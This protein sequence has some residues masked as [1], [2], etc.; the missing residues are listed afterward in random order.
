MPP[1]GSR[2]EIYM[3]IG[4]IFKIRSAWNK[5]T[6]THPKF[7]QFISAVQRK[8]IK[9]N[10]IIEIKITDPDGTELCSNIRV[11]ASDLELFDELKDIRG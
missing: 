7:P 5:F 10:T 3:N 4:S 1:K 6:N 8:G 11:T 9:E 2:M